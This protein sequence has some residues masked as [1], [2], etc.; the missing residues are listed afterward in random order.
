MDGGLHL[1]ITVADSQQKENILEDLNTVLSDPKI[2]ITFV[3]SQ[4]SS[5]KTSG[6][7][8]PKTQPIVIVPREIENWVAVQHEAPSGEQ[9]IDQQARSETV[10][11]MEHAERL[12]AHAQ[13]LRDL[14]GR[15]DQKEL[16]TLN[17]TEERPWTTACLQHLLAAQ[18]ESISLVYQLDKFFPDQINSPIEKATS[19]SSNNYLAAISSVSRQLE[20]NA[21]ALQAAFSHPNSSANTHTTVLHIRHNLNLANHRLDAIHAIME[22]Q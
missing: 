18:S 19:V 14:V 9:E 21:L 1:Q 15:F 20:Q 5:V 4:E 2:S 6:S 12:Q 13:A 16:E 3:V 22:P 17:S 8:I 11:L 10:A 7:A